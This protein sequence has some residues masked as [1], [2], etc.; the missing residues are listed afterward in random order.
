[1]IEAGPAGGSGVGRHAVTPASWRHNWLLSSVWLVFLAF[2]LLSLWVGSQT[3]GAKLA[4]S[5]LV[6]V[7]GA[8]Y[9][10]GFW[11]S[12]RRSVEGLRPDAPAGP[13]AG[14]TVD[15]G[16]T[17][18]FLLAVLAV[19]AG[20]VAGWAM[21]GLVPF[22]ASFAVFH[23]SWPRA[24]AV[25]AGCTVLVVLLPLV[26]GVYG[27]LWVLTPIS[28]SVALS[29]VLIRWADEREQERAVLQ[30]RLAVSDER[31]RVARDVHD[32]LGHSLTAVVLKAELVQ[33]LLE[34]VDPI[35]DG[36]GP[37]R[38]LGSG[39][40]ADV[41]D[42]CRAEVAE[43]QVISRRALAEI[44]ATVGGLR[45]A[46]LAD[47]VSVARM[48]LADA[49]VV[50]TVTGDQSTVPERYQPT[51]AWV[52]REAVTNV[53]RHARADTCTIE[54]GPT[55]DST[56]TRLLRVVD[57]GLGMDSD[58][59]GNGLRGLRERVEAV[60]ASLRVTSAA[61]TELEVLA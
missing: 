51:L 6:A 38:A 46:N 1:M 13:P 57:D 11:H 39:S 52:V 45:T 15:V 34:R 24:L 49:G 44:R 18:L 3:L 22:I 21:L 8:V 40:E 27:N 43:L 54:L 50:L 17:A 31:A 9:A 56:P 61:G 23:L 28:I 2:P 26:G 14:R 20:V 4:G 25:A 19:V 32:V 33:R 42:R 41:V 55:D 7:F 30:T 12:I 60:G 29:T 48:V 47:E 53:V 36:T 5:A 10:W 37:D 58:R 35:P 16:H 59:E